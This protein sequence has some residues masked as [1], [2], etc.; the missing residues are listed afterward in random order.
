[1]SRIEY[2]III[3]GRTRL[4]LLVERF[5]TR[6]QAKFYIERNG[7]DL[8]DYESEHEAFH[9]ALDH[10]Q[11]SIHRTI[12]NKVV[13]R[14][15]LPS[16]IFSDDQVVI[17]IGQDG[18]LANAAKYVGGRP[19]IGVNP[20]PSRY[21]GVL[22][23]FTAES[24]VNALEQ[25]ISG[26][27]AHRDA[28]LAEARLNDG[29]RLLAFNDLFI[30]VSDHTSARYRIAFNG[31][32][33]EHS[34][35]GI[36]VATRSGST[37]WLSSMYNMANGLIRGPKENVR[38]AK[39]LSDRELQFVVREPFQSQRTG[40]EIASGRINERTALTVTSLMPDRGV[41]FSDGIA[42]D[43]L[44]FNA[45][46]VATIGSAQEKARLVLPQ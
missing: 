4:E 34:S 6:S 35:S 21:D 9:A 26:T 20:D 10:V 46:A 12:K 33:E 19:M 15:F 43:H 42:A 38:K 14:A 30:G 45:G 1:M 17:T 41:I 11:R 3:R 2:A 40:T 39:Q 16:F 13:E 5:N 31:S 23:P 7:G 18:L 8:T 28:S 24:T 37:G 27:Y 44:R 29:Q 22:L 36:L 32:E 25:V